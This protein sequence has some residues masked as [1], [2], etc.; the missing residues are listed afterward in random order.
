MKDYIIFN[1]EKLSISD[2]YLIIPERKIKSVKE[3]IE[4]FENENQRNYIESLLINNNEISDISGL[5]AFPNLIVLYLQNNKIQ[6]I[7]MIKTLRGL[8]KLV[9]A[10]NLINNIETIKD[11]TN[12]E[13]LD[14]SYNQIEKIEY[15]DNL[16]NLKYLDLGFN[17]IS[18]IENLDNTRNLKELFLSGNEN[19]SKIKNLDNLVNLRVLIIGGLS[20]SRIEGLSKLINLNALN[21]LVFEN[22]GKLSQIEG[23]EYLIDLE[24]IY[25]DAF[26]FDEESLSLKELTILYR[27]PCLIKNKKYERIKDW[28]EVFREFPIIFNLLKLKNP[29]EKIE[30]YI[31]QCSEKLIDVINKIL[32]NL[33]Y[34]EIRKG[35][36]K[37]WND[38]YDYSKKVFSRKG[39]KRNIL[40]IVK[41]ELKESEDEDY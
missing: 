38:I 33:K 25:F 22:S 41:K 11:L 15:L 18:K 37:Q 8:K 20:I 7:S 26:N 17:N 10:K 36:E 31:E 40:D 14:L 13:Y 34:K 24:V 3:I 9:L 4:A 21:V 23:L 6:D 39:P 19:I 12:L 2:N 1:G 29:H 16:K 28:K 27:F 5:E 35:Q 32:H 30:W